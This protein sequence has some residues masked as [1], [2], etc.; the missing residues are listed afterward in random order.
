MDLVFYL[1]LFSFLLLFGLI[2]NN[3]DFDFWARLI[4]GKSFF[5]TGSLFNYDF[6]SYGT[7]HKFIDHEWGSSLVFYLIQ[8]YFSDIGL[9]IFKT[10]IIFLTL[11]LIT[12]IIRLKDNNIPLYFLFFFFSLHSICYTIFSTIR[13]Q[14]FS[15][16]FF[17]FYLYILELARCKKDYKVLFCLPI[18]NII[19]ANLHGGFLV[20]LVLILLFAF[21]E[22]LNNRKYMPYL[23]IFFISSLT[24]LA[25]P[26]GFEYISYIIKAFS[27]NRVHIVEWQSAFFS[28]Y[29]KI[30]LTS[31]IKFKTFF[32]ISIIIFIYSIFKNIKLSGFKKF[33]TQIDKTKYLIILF[34]TIISI[35]AMRCH[36]FF[37]YSVLA[38]C[39][40][41]FYKIFNKK[42]PLVFDKTKE[43]ILLFLVL[44]STISHINPKSPIFKTSENQYP[45]HCIEFIKI[46]NLKGN[47]LTNFHEGSYGAYK[48]YPN[49]LIFMDG[50]YEEVYDNNLINELARFYLAY[51]YEDLLKKYKSD[52]LILDKYYPVVEKLKNNKDWFLAYED[53][54]YALFLDKKYKNN[55][56]K[57]PSNDENYYN[58]E[59]FKTN[60]N[61][62]N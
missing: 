7:T 39:Y 10:L 3:I 53:K 47:V 35:K 31:F 8:N 48:L 62:V 33:Y 26:W 2:D 20:G 40:S 17:V 36:P 52:I 51:N 29:S 38:Y 58:R 55:N 37:V 59:K 56:F 54:K 16:L 9:L 61:W 28:K 24:S 11:F 6:Y 34:T 27:L 1:T 57:M 32:F 21:G 42:L 19:W 30:Y 14:T 46:N 18:L 60:I 4:V 45:I 5:Q 25:N 49:N 13:C 22:F 50:R 44:I 12:K 41:D 15:F 23:I 43:F